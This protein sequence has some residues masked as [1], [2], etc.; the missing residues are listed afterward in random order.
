MKFS[1][2]PG[3]IHVSFQ[4]GN[5]HMT[6]AIE[7]EGNPITAEQEKHLFER[8]YKADDSRTAHA[9]QS[10]SGLG[11]SI[12]KNIFELHGGT[13]RLRHEDGHFTFTVRLPN[14]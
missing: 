1:I 14:R 3:Q 9:I 5:G 7:N 2:K 10:G 13:I 8:F 4:S 12:A 11:L 6:V